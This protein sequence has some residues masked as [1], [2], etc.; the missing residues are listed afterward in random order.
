MRYT[1]KVFLTPLI[2]V[3]AALYA[4]IQQIYIL[5]YYNPGTAITIANQGPLFDSS[6]FH[7][8]VPESPGGSQNHSLVIVTGHLP[9]EDVSWLRDRPSLAHAAK[10]IYAINVNATATSSSSGSGGLL[11]PANK[12]H[13]AMIYLTYIIDNYPVFP[14]VVVFIHPHETAWHNNILNDLSTATTLERLDLGVVVRQGYFNL[15]CHLDPGCPRW[16]EVDRWRRWWW[17]W[18]L[19]R[20]PEEGF[21]T[22]G[23]FR[24]L[25][26]NGNGNGDGDGDGEVGGVG[27]VGVGVPRWMSQPCC[28]QFAVSGER[29]RGRSKGFYERYRKWLM[30]TE[31]VD[32][33]SGRVMEYSWQYLFTGLWEWCPSQHGC[34]CGGY[35]VCFEGREEGLQRWLRVLRGRERVDE[36][37][38]GLERKGRR[39][40]KGYEALVEESERIGRELGTMRDEALRRGR[41]ARVRAEE[42]GRVW[43]EGDGY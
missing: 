12:G 10:A 38:R 18:D 28:A 8:G 43:R 30:Q 19:K 20:K 15:R 21:L 29:I 42:C 13:E 3:S 39:R 32:E 27:G 5:L 34:Y 14:D 24:E 16:L 2:L 9:D 40:G 26:G 23:L 17:G 37:I 31:L 11:L 4:I 41:D 25:H 33:M 7:A 1:R 6:I 22:S 36:K 35:G